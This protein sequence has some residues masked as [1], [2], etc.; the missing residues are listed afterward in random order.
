MQ[1]F[2]NNLKHCIFCEVETL[3]F[4]FLVFILLLYNRFPNELKTHNIKLLS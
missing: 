4:L 3:L 1:S 2:I